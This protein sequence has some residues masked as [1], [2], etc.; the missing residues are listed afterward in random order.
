MNVINTVKEFSVNAFSSIVSSVS[1]RSA[2][3][4]EIATNAVKKI[5]LSTNQKIIGGVV[6]ISAA[7]LT[8]VRK[9]I[10]ESLSTMSKA[11]SNA[12]SSTFGKVKEKISFFNPTSNPTDNS[13]SSPT[14][15]S[16]DNSTSS[17]TD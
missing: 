12:V 13:T 10:S 4:S 14:D 8:I 7:A 11:V 16:T 5:N 3:I 17:S 2:Q 15:N 6:V 1:K 9:K